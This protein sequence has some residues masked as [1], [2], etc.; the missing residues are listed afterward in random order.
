VTG[1]VGIRL[2]IVLSLGVAAAIFSG[3]GLIASLYTAD[4]DVRR[5]GAALL[6]L[7]AVYHVVDAA[8]A[9]AVNAVR[10]YKKT[11]VPMAIYVAAL[12]GLGLGGGYAL[13]VVGLGG[14]PL[15]AAGFWIGGILGMTATAVAMTLYF[16]RVSRHAVEDAA[17]ERCAAA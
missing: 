16:L 15:R 2:G 1:L 12:W 7:V 6:A 14:E 17:R 10:A 9:V 8:Q 4:P 5:I 13:G 11:T 3:A